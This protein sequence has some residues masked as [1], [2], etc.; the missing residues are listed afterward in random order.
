MKTWKK[1]PKKTRSKH[2][3]LPVPDLSGQPKEWSR[4]RLNNIK[5]VIIPEVSKPKIDSI[6]EKSKR[7]IKQDYLSKKPYGN[8]YYSI[9]ALSNKSRNRIR[10]NLQ[11]DKDNF[12]RYEVLLD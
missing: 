11:K 9:L 10:S 2:S 5:G 3:T 4:A 1:I 8:G 6:I 12:S 7:M